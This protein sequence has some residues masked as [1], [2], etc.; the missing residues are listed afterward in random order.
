[1]ADM[2]AKGRDRHVSLPGELNHT[3]K[4]NADAVR[5][6][7]RAHAVG[8]ANYTELAAR[9]RVSRRTIKLAVLRETW[10]HVP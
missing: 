1:M 5:E 3:S 8:E 7:R 2:Y 4:L 6:I 9:F 10:E